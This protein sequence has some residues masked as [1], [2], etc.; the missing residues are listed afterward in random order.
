MKQKHEHDDSMSPEF[1]RKVFEGNTIGLKLDLTFS[2]LVKVLYYMNQH[3]FS[4][5]H[6]S[7]RKII[8]ATERNNIN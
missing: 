2:E 4:Y 1:I 7:M 5:K 8:L 6:E 3:P